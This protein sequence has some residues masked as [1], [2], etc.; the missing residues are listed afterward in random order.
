SG[1]GAENFF[2]LLRVLL[3]PYPELAP[4]PILL[5]LVVQRLEADAE[6]LGGAGLVIARVLESAQNQSLLG[7]LDRG[8]DV[9]LHRVAVLLRRRSRRGNRGSGR[10]RP[11]NGASRT[12]VRLQEGREM[13]R[14]DGAFAR[15]NHGAFE[16][17]PQFAHVARPV[18]TFERLDHRRRDLGDPA[19]VLSI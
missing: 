17:V 12:A 8:A 14:L 11:W 7:L 2:R 5:E 13:A 15:E 18:V 19:I 4:G 6:D 3:N 1:E 16:H 9:E 10:S